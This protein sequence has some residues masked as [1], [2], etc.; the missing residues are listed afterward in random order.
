MLPANKGKSEWLRSGLFHDYAAVANALAPD[1]DAQWLRFFSS[2][3]KG[4]RPMPLMSSVHPDLKDLVTT[5]VT[6]QAYANS[7]YPASVSKVGNVVNDIRIE[8]NAIRAGD[9]P[10]DADLLKQLYYINKSRKWLSSEGLPAEHAA[11]LE[12]R[13]WHH[14]R[15]R[16]IPEF[17]EN[18]ICLDQ[19]NCKVQQAGTSREFETWLRVSH[20]GKGVSMPV[21]TN[22]YAD[23]H[24]GKTK[25][26][27]RIRFNQHKHRLEV[28]FIKAINYGDSVD[29]YT[30]ACDALDKTVALD[31]GLR[32]VF[33]SDS[34]NRYGVDLIDYMVKLDKRIQH[35]QTQCQKRKFR[36]SRSKR[37]RDMIHRMRTTIDRSINEALNA[38]V[39][40][41]RPSMIV[42]ERLNFMHPDLSRR[43]NRLIRNCGRAA[44]ERKLNALEQEF[45]IEHIEVNA[46]YSSQTCSQCGYVDLKN[47]GT[48]DTF[49]CRWCA[50]TDCADTNAASNILTRRSWPKWW[51]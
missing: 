20:R 32:N 17:R 15:R 7:V 39:K 41:E 10:P 44:V 48:R 23:R 22:S 1:L 37:Y 27:Y 46:A 11:W 14:C 47:R 16:C 40:T 24:D 21:E 26:L 29:A 49:K 12:D 51:L 34:G 19:R 50:H 36:L 18:V 33:V 9:N 5:T 35:I 31:F 30:K 13:F 3:D 38:V 2:Q 4:D 43:M 25:G 8:I 45:G 42:V 6:Q 28:D